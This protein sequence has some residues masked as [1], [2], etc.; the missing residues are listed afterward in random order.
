MVTG[1]PQ[2]VTKS[3]Y[4]LNIT[5]YSLHFLS[6]PT[7]KML[8][9]ITHDHSRHTSDPDG[10]QFNSLSFQYFVPA[11]VAWRAMPASVKLYISMPL[12]TSSAIFASTP[13]SPD[14]AAASAWPPNSQ[15][16]S[17]NVLSAY[18]TPRANH[19]NHNY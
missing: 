9:H 13:L 7:A 8:Y 5:M 10:Y 2:Q 17:T 18:E 11:M 1:Q 12:V 15:P 16:L 6:S 3:V 4:S 14:L 19:T